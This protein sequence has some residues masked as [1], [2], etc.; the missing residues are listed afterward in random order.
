MRVRRGPATVTGCRCAARRVRQPL[1]GPRGRPGRRGTEPEARRPTSDRIND[2]RRKGDPYADSI[3]ARSARR[4]RCRCLACRRHDGRRRPYQRE[5]SHR[6]AG[7]HDLRRARY[8]R[9][10]DRHS[11]VGM[12]SLSVIVG[13]LDRWDITR[14]AV[15][16]EDRLLDAVRTRLGNQVET[17]RTLPVEPQTSN[18]PY[19]DW[20]RIGLPVTVFPRWLRCTACDRLFP[21]ASGAAQARPQPVS[22]RPNPLHPPKLR[23]GPEATTSSPRPV[24]RGGVRQRPPR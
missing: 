23:R 20:A 24:R 12:P 18:N 14:Q 1:E 8:D 4:L 15:V 5:P 3:H 7:V 10:Q 19:D 11:F 22:D 16:T 9:R 17:L 21:V 6:R 13:G 2:P